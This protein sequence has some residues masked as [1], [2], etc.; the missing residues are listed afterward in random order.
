MIEWLPPVVINKKKEITVVVNKEKEITVVLI[1]NYKIKTNENNIIKF[2][3]Y[4]IKRLN[5]DFLSHGF[6]LI[7][8]NLDFYVII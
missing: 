5:I 8:Q 1:Q 3:Y 2:K 7:F 6:D 4:S